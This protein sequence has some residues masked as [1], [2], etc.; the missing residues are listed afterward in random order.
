MSNSA[1]D[2]KKSIFSFDILKILG[3][4]G[5]FIPLILTFFQYRQSV[6][7]DYA[8]N[9]R[10]VVS[11]LSSEKTE[12]RIASATNLGTFIEKGE[13]YYNE[14][15]DIL[16]N[17]VSNELNYNVLNA[18]RGSLEKTNPEDYQKVIQ[19]LL[20]IDRNFFFYESDT[21]RNEIAGYQEIVQ[22]FIALF[23]G[24]TR[25][26]KI[27]DL[28][29]NQN[30]L[31]YTV[32]SE[33]LLSKAIFKNSALEGSIISETEFIDSKII[34]TVFSYSEL[35]QCNF[36]NTEIFSSLFFGNSFLGVNFEGT[37]FKDVFFTDSD[38][39]GADF[40]KTEGLTPI[41]FYRCKNLDKAK[42]DQSFK[43][44]LT[45]L[46]VNDSEFFEHVNQS[47]LTTQRINELKSML[48]KGSENQ[49]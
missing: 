32:L 43:M 24:I 49:P 4:L 23:L 45:N 13:S 11:K 17:A 2:G 33:V 29:F 8:K 6:Q 48:K 3:S 41:Y 7:Q 19:K 42:F 9:F 46:A 21:N 15:I 10:E 16:V 44:Q 14:A 37:R 28:R 27:E 40:T 38:L 47:S 25:T 18:I 31:R 30:S 34:N 12:E 39:S 35:S 26:N 22:R 1:D 5:I 20:N 36:K